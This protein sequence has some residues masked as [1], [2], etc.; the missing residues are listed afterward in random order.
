MNTEEYKKLIG[1]MAGGFTIMPNALI[2]FLSPKACKV[3]MKTVQC[4]F[5]MKSGQVGNGWIRVATSY[6]VTTL[7]INRKTVQSALSELSALNLIASTGSGQRGTLYRINWEEV[8]VIC[9]VMSKL[10]ADGTERIR[11]ICSQDGMIPVSRIDEQKLNRLVKDFARGASSND[12]D[13]LVPQSELV[14]SSN[15]DPSY[16]KISTRDVELVESSNSEMSWQNLPTQNGELVENANSDS[17]SCPKVSTHDAEL[18][19]S[20]NSNNVSCPKISTRDTQE[21][22]LVES[23]NSAESSCPK[24]PT[25]ESELVKSSNSNSAS[26]QNVSTRDAELV[27]SS[28]SHD[29]AP[30]TAELVES[31]NS[32]LPVNKN[33]QLDNLS[34]QKIPTRGNDDEDDGTEP[35]FLGEDDGGFGTP[36]CYFLPCRVDKNGQLDPSELVESSTSIYNNKIKKNEGGEA[37]YRGGK[38]NESLKNESLE[39]GLEG[40]EKVKVEKKGMEAGEGEPAGVPS[41][42]EMKRQV[43]QRRQEIAERKGEEE[44]EEGVGGWAKK[45]EALR[46]QTRKKVEILKDYFAS[47]DESYV[48]FG[49][50]LLESIMEEPI[51][52]GDDN[53]VKT[54]KQV[55]PQLAYEEGDASDNFVPLDFFHNVLF[56]SW[57]DLKD[58]YPDYTLTED[59]LKS[60]FCFEFMEHDGEVQFC[61]NP[62]M[63]K[64][65][66]KEEDIKPREIAS[67]KKKVLYGDRTSRRIF[68]ETIEEVAKEDEALLTDAE[69]NVV[70]LTEQNDKGKRACWNTEVLPERF[71]EILKKF[72]RLSNVPAEDIK[73]KLFQDLPGRGRIT[74]TPNRLVPDRFFEYNRQVQQDSEVERRFLKK[75]DEERERLRQQAEEEDD[76][77]DDGDSKP[78]G[79]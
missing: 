60:I 7:G 58:Q 78:E 64:D 18:V 22:E 16:P 42:D 24:I 61:I 57:S 70:L 47:R 15:S 77:W 30:Q 62:A 63:V 69:F 68:L 79:V 34:W 29:S 17:T 28:N 38:V 8:L 13:V 35:T 55:W 45:Q 65:L 21:S 56:H 5:T 52:E 33:G 14:E 26:W 72:E 39:G 59:D 51:S 36:S 12:V 40:E 20:A 54:I 73:E 2:D 76:G 4:L 3:F 67:R 48:P 41:R 50:S 46:S 11:K 10:S 49:V 75:L 27:E 23:S 74:L 6:Y 32:D 19:E 43:E 25:Q 66:R 9:D 37:P 31:S 53:V 1:Q 44:V 71:D